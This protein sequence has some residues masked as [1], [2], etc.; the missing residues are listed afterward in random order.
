M[1][2]VASHIAFGRVDWFA[3]MQAP[4]SLELKM[5]AE[6]L[7]AESAIAGNKNEIARW[8]ED[9]WQMVANTL[10]QW[11]VQ[12]LWRIFRQKYYGNIYNVSYQWTIWRILGHDLHHGGQLAIM[13]GI[14]GID[15]PELGDL[16]G[17]IN[18][19]PLAKPE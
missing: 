10:S 13:L 6:T 8:L 18:M 11:T 4:G 5:K 2:E 3:R 1:G 7:G 9:S 15:I 16:G 17:H 14:Q 12:D 19:P